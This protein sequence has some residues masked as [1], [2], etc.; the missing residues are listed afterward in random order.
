MAK[1]TYAAFKTNSKREQEG[2]VLDMGD[3]GKYKIA[4]AG[5][6]NSKFS[7]RLAVLTKPH[8]RAIQTDTIDRKV[9][10]EILAT[11]YA[12]TVLI[13][14]EGVSGEDGNELAFSKE[15]AIKLFTDLPDLFKQIRETAEDM[16]LFREELAEGDA[17]N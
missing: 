15:N 9:A 11:A 17:G 1:G 13:G 4:R 16:T 7:R 12:E 8:R 3:A 2:V 14:W 10:D 5:G 6:A